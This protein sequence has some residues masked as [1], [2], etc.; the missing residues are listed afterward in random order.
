M[1]SLQVARPRRNYFDCD[2]VNSASPSGHQAAHFMT[3]EEHLSAFKEVG[4]I[5]AREICSP[6]T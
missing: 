3:V 4:F 6:P 2:H 5:K 1:R